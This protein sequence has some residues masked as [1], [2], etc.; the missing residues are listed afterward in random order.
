MYSKKYIRELEN[1]RINKKF[2]N[3]K[4]YATCTQKNILENQR[5]RELIRNLKI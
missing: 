5:I 4:I 1:Q 3:I 2:K